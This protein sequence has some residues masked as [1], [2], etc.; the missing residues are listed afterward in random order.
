MIVQVMLV[1]FVLLFINNMVNIIVFLYVDYLVDLVD[2]IMGYIK[3]ISFQF[4][5]RVSCYLVSWCWVVV[6]FDNVIY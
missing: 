3:I 2:M 4:N 1:N 5:Y 6:W